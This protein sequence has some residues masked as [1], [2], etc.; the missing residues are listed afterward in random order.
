MEGTPSRVALAPSRRSVEIQR[1]N[2]LDQVSFLQ[3]KHT[4]VGDFLARLVDE[5]EPVTK[6]DI[7]EAIALLKES[8]EESEVRRSLDRVLSSGVPSEK[9]DQK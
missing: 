3:E 7:F 8:R 6:F 1:D 5:V 2:A 9:E 4:R